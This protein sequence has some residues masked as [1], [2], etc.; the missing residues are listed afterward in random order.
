M[1]FFCCY[2]LHFTSQRASYVQRQVIF[3][4][5]Q[6]TLQRF[7]SFAECGRRYSM[8]NHLITM[9]QGIFSR[10]WI[11][12]TFQARQ[13]TLHR[14]MYPLM[15]GALVIHTANIQFCWSFSNVTLQFLVNVTKSIRWPRFL[16]RIGYVRSQEGWQFSHLRFSVNW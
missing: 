3:T 15:I 2:I 9:I 6:E 4:R 12:V 14:N 5:C 16:S 8:I 13:T 1:P 7:R 10:T 11:T